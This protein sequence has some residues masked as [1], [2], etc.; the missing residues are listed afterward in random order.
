MWQSVLDCSECSS[1]SF[2]HVEVTGCTNGIFLRNKSQAYQLKHKRPEASSMAIW[3][4]SPEQHAPP[5]LPFF[6][7]LTEPTR[8]QSPKEKLPPAP[9]NLRAR[10]GREK[11]LESVIFL[12]QMIQTNSI[13]LIGI[14]STFCLLWCFIVFLRVWLDLNQRVT[15]TPMSPL[16]KPQTFLLEGIGEGRK[17]IPLQEPRTEISPPRYL[18]L[19]FVSFPS[20]SYPQGLL[21]WL[22][23]LFPL[24]VLKHPQPHSRT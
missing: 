17:A 8:P 3:P 19:W 18:W 6:I 5:A 20:V 1:E 4:N 16:P 22:L 21:L 2:H 11:S 15:A 10:I 13:N 23:D 12:K 9:T 7:H 14:L 24:L